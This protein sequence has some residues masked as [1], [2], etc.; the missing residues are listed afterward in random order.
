M[1]SPILVLGVLMACAAL[2]AVAAA[3]AI[4]L[5][6]AYRASETATPKMLVL[7][8]DPARGTVRRPGAACRGLR[9]IGPKAFAPTPKGMVCADIFG[10]PMRAVVTG[11]Y[12]GFRVWVRLSRVDGCAIARWDRVGFLLPPAAS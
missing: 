9:A 6:I 11:S 3:G 7:R 5:R 2:P 8:C 12:F 10:G 4:D 1:R